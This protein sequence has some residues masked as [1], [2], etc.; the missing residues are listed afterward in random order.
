MQLLTRDVLRS[1][2]GSMS[3]LA[4]QLARP[5]ARIVP[6]DDP[7]QAEVQLGGLPLLPDGL[8]WP[9]WDGYPLD[10]VADVD[11]A[12]VRRELPTAPLP[13]AGS[14]ALFLASSLFGPA[15]ELVGALEPRSR[16]G[17]RLVHIPPGV[18]RRPVAP[19]PVADNPLSNGPYRTVHGRLA[20][21]LTVPDAWESGLPEEWN[22][23]PV[24]D[25]LER[26]HELDWGGPF[27]RIGG[28]PQPTQ[29]APAAP[30]ALAAAGL[31]APDGTV[32]WN[33]P[34]V[35]E[36]TQRANDDW[37]LALQLDTDD[38]E[39][40]PGWMWGDVGVVF[41]YGRPTDLRD[42]ATW[43]EAW[44]NWDCH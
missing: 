36:V 17:W 34:R 11:L 23:D 27:H 43:H 13:V 4:E 6:V 25:A 16:P 29:S 12:A 2:F 26:L 40:G 8:E 21:E 37:W 9:T 28:W 5:S 30:P 3:P 24:Y 32:E 15:G 44:L 14:M 20:A 22:D 1:V 19:P 7:G 42:A 18:D 31:T 33:D 39:D 38:D 10:F 35:Q 41:V